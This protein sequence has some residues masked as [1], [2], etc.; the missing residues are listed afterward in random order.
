MARIDDGSEE[1]AEESGW[2]GRKNGPFSETTCSSPMW[3]NAGYIL[4]Q[5]QAFQSTYHSTKYKHREVET[6]VMLNVPYECTQASLKSPLLRPLNASC[7][8]EFKQLHNTILFP[9]ERRTRGHTY[10]RRIA[11]DL[12]WG[13]GFELGVGSS[14]CGLKGGGG[15]EAIPYCID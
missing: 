11:R 2:S 7:E 5:S 4:L 12:W 10:Q 6:R 9:V 15:R 1:M 8:I 13:C 3:E 14:D